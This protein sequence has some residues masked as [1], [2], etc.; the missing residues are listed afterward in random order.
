MADTKNEQAKAKNKKINRMTLE[1]LDKAIENTKQ[2]Q[3]SMN[4]KYG[5]ELLKQR[6][7]LSTK[8]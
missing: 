6:E 5:K 4:S 1:E 8:K 7:V 2:N 3:G